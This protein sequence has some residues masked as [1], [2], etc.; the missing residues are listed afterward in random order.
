MRKTVFSFLVTTLLTAIA[1]GRALA[2]EAAQAV[3]AA[4]TEPAAQAAGQTLAVSYDVGIAATLLGIFLG[5]G[6]II[7]ARLLPLYRDMAINLRTLAGEV[8]GNQPA[9]AGEDYEAV[10]KAAKALTMAGWIFIVMSIGRLALGLAGW[11]F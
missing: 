10:P 11:S 7:S 9:G 4:P 2:E 8:E 3:A 1:H 6:M 5:V